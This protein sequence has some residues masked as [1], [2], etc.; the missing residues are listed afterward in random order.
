MQPLILN[1]PEI[2]ITRRNTRNELTFHS[3][4]ESVPHDLIL[5]CRHHFPSLSLPY[6]RIPFDFLFKFNFLLTLRHTIT[7]YTTCEWRGSSFYYSRPTYLGEIAFYRQNR[8][9]ASFLPILYVIYARPLIY[10]F[11]AYVGIR[12][13]A[14]ASPFIANG[15]D[16]AHRYRVAAVYL[17]LQDWWKCIRQSSIFRTTRASFVLNEF[18]MKLKSAFLIVSRLLVFA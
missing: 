14:L 18:P 8:W 4:R 13:D 11:H 17:D 6:C 15:V 7:V 16:I 3:S 9:V 10:L 1:I 2:R 12:H 5:H